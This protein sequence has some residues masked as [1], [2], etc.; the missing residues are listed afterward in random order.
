MKRSLALALMLCTLA[1][2]GC[3]APPSGC[4][5]SSPAGSVSL[6]QSNHPEVLAVLQNYR[7]VDGAESGTLVL[8]G[9][10]EHEVYTL[11][12][13][14]IPV[15]L[16][17]QKA[18]PSV[19]EDGMM[20][21]ISFGG[22]IMETWPAQFGG[23]TSISVHSLGS[24][25][26]PG[27]TTYDLCGLYLQVLSDLWEKDAGLNGGAEY[28]SVDLNQAPGDLTEGEK[29]A[30]A[31][32]FAGQHGVQPL[33]LTQEELAAEGYL[34]EVPLMSGEEGLQQPRRTFYT[35]EDG[36]LFSITANQ[37]AEGERYS[38]PVVNFDA[39]KWRTP[40]GAYYFSNCTALWPQ[41]GTWSGYE[42][43]GEMIS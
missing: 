43:G 42:I 13:E 39:Q 33:T 8:A 1:L 15:F 6:P 11:N 10:G 36:L 19:L 16:D 27:G 37:W 9:D 18:D 7:I 35:W 12:V 31:W 3:Q 21:E 30:I 38:L 4:A 23:V 25:E 32:I 40:L 5:L 2:S 14:N 20:A 34:T 26:N 22:E 29:A 28:V 41:I 17:G 24:A